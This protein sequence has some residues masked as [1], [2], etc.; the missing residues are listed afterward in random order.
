MVLGKR[1]HTNGNEKPDCIEQ[2]YETV[3]NAQ[4]MVN[5]PFFIRWSFFCFYTH[6]G[7]P[8]VLTV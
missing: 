1:K 5:T 8:L 4:M 2:R 7:T 3:V 6:S